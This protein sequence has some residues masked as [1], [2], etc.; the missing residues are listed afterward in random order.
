MVGYLVLNFHALPIKVNDVSIQCYGVTIQLFPILTSIAIGLTTQ[1]ILK[2]CQ[3]KGYGIISAVKEFIGS[4]ISLAAH[5]Q[6]W[7]RCFVTIRRCNYLLHNK[8]MI[9]LFH[10]F[11]MHEN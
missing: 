11:F 10:V 1:V 2:V 7:H 5:Q 3:Y 4:S 8:I 9:K 6:H